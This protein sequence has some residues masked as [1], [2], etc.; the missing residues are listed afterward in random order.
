MLLEF[1]AAGLVVAFGLL[2]IGYFT[3][4]RHFVVGGAVALLVLGLFLAVDGFE[5]CGVV[6]HTSEESYY[7]NGTCNVTDLFEV[8]TVRNANAYSIENGALTAGLLSD[9]YTT[10]GQYLQIK[11]N[12]AGF[13]VTYNF[14]CLV[15][16]NPALL[17]FA[18]RY[19]GPSN[20]RFDW[21]GYN[22][23]S[24]AFVNLGFATVTASAIDQTLSYTCPSSVHLIDPVTGKVMVKMVTT[25]AAAGAYYIY[26]DYIALVGDSGVFAEQTMMVDCTR[27]LINV[28]YYYG[29]CDQTMDFG[30]S[31]AMALM[32]MLGGLGALLVNWKREE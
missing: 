25:N 2:I 24:G 12:G 9:T 18:G 28:T 20:R 30:F 19:Q 26:T 16:D 11:E 10:N 31:E 4:K 13:N 23:T 29:A 17:E 7:W 1:F 8:E 3:E 27:D 6:D 5:A 14:T 32:L 15:S 22:W 21:Y